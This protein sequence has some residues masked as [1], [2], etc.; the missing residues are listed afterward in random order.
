MHERPEAEAA[1]HRDEEQHSAPDAQDPAAQGAP[2]AVVVVLAPPLEDRLGEDVVVELVA[3]R[4]VARHGRRH[5]AEDAAALASA[6][7]VQDRLH[8][9]FLVTGPLREIGRAVGDLGLR[10][11][12]E[13]AEEIRRHVLLARAQRSER[14]EQVVL[15]DPLRPS[16]PHR[17]ARP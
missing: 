14:V 11:R 7:L 13:E 16:E 3:R 2:P 1:D 8:D 17:A 15:D 5:A 9:A 4:A 6:E 12:D 10:A